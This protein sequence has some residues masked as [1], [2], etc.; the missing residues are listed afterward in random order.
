M[1][2]A[3]IVVD[4]KGELA[5]NKPE[6]LFS[7]HSA[8]CS[9]ITYTSVLTRVTL[10]EVHTARLRSVS[11]QMLRFSFC[12]SYIANA[13]REAEPPFSFEM[14]LHICMCTYLYSVSSAHSYLIIL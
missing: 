13:E 1:M 8:H 6:K 3:Q 14:Y 4:N 2:L 12:N 10:S 11:F 7:N 9:I 5:H